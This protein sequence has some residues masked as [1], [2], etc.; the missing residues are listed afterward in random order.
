M[1]RE[2]SIIDFKLIWGKIN[3]TLSAE[4]D[5]FL[6]KWLSESY[7]HQQY[8]DNAERFH[9]QGSSFTDTKSETERAWREL[10]GKLNKESHLHTKWILP[11]ITVASVVIILIVIIITRDTKFE[12]SNVASTS[13]ETA[14]PIP[15]GANKATLTL[16]DGSIHHL[17][18]TGNLILTEDGATILSEGSKLKYTDKEIIPQ[19]I[20]YNTLTVPRGGEFSLQLSDGTKVWLNSETVLHYPV[21]F[22][23][24][25]R[26]VELTGEAFFDVVRNEKS[27]FFVESGQQTVE[28]FGTE[29]NISCYKESQFVYTTLV[30]GS[31]EVFCSK[32][33]EIRQVLAP[34][35]QSRLGKSDESISK[36][37]VDPYQYIAWKEGRFVFRNQNLEEIM[38]N[39]A[40][41]YDVEVLFA[42]E[43]LKGVKF[44]GNLKR[45]E[46]FGEVLKKIEKTHEVEFQI[47]GKKITIR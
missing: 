43:G 3:H 13:N 2:R 4:E 23:D 5:Q 20:K 28:V 22:S 15:P 31:V 44:T 27:P 10:Q 47:E 8:F 35:E 16:N 19:K 7:L 38:S 39:L 40:K 26:R 36:I 21:Q 11:L 9:K 45:Y 33:P 1:P 32:K 6:S 25:E 29:F 12:P 24:K 41:W 42:N 14:Q 30:K 18:S 46:D 17:T 34:N 37:A